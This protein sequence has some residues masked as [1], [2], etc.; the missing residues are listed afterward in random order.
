VQ[1]QIKTSDNG[2]RGEMAKVASEKARPHLAAKITTLI[3]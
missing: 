1:H 3:K 2:E